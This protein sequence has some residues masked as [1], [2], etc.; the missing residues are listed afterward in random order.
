MNTRIQRF[1]VPAGISLLTVCLLPQLARSQ[2]A[3]PAIPQVGA[4]GFPVSPQQSVKAKPTRMIKMRPIQKRPLKLKLQERNPYAGRSIEQKTAANAGLDS[5]ESRI[6]TKLGSLGVSG[7]SRG[8]NNDLKVQMG[9]ITLE[10]GKVLPPL[11]EDQ[12]VNLQVIELTDEI[13][14][15]G[16]LD[17]E[18]MERTGKEM[19]VPYDLSP[20]IMYQLSGQALSANDPGVPSAAPV[21]GFLKVGKERRSEAARIA[22]KDPARG[23]SREIYEAAQ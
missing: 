3:T 12:T 11:I 8:P 4:N 16:W 1:V 22:A 20:R 19:Q 23:L 17:I 9:D 21:M 7:S 6:R 18:T 5:E 15:L 2:D 10:K 14:T 13:I